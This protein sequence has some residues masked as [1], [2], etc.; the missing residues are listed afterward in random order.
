MSICRALTNWAQKQLICFLSKSRVSQTR[1]IRIWLNLSW[2]FSRQIIRVSPKF[3][4]SQDSTR[5]GMNGHKPFAT[6]VRTPTPRSRSLSEVCMRY[7]RVAEEW[8]V[9]GRF[10]SPV[11]LSHC[12]DR[13]QSAVRQDIRIWT[14][15]QLI[16]ERITYFDSK[17]RIKNG[18]IIFE[19]Q[20]CPEI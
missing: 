4:T 9:S 7:Q 5:T 14:V 12:F 17:D 16:D 6:A 8:T 11:E 15:S 19:Q 18:Q 20:Q 10:W 13:Q 2:S 1:R 3:S